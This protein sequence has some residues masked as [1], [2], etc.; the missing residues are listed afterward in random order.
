[1]LPYNQIAC[2]LHQKENVQVV[3]RSLGQ[4]TREIKNQSKDGYYNCIQPI[5]GYDAHY[6]PFLL[7]KDRYNITVIN[8]KT[9][10]SRVLMDCEYNNYENLYSMVQWKEDGNV[11]MA[12]IYNSGDGVRSVKE[13]VI[14]AKV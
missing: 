10:E 13:F 5:S 12:T 1:M 6:L 9:W 8:T 4:V 7:L 11:R 3:N 2:C 14:A